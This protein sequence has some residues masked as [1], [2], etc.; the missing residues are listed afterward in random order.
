MERSNKKI[1]G[2]VENQSGAKE[3][4]LEAIILG[5]LQNIF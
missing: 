4:D 5:D 3:K 2:R 1:Y